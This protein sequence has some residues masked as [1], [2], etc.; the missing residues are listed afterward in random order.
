MLKKAL[1]LAFVI[2]HRI[3]YISTAG[4]KVRQCNH[5]FVTQGSYLSIS[6]L[7]LQNNV[8]YSKEIN[9]SS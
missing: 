8:F 7:V 3:N 5:L 1:I 9:L 6:L 4:Q 2:R